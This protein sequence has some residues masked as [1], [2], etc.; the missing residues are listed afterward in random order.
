MMWHRF[1]VT[2]GAICLAGLAALANAQ[3]E[4]AP[5]VA[6]HYPFDIDVFFGFGRS[7][8]EPS[9]VRNLVAKLKRPTD[10][11]RN[12]SWC[13]LVLGYADRTEGNASATA[14]LAGRR[15]T[16]VKNIILTTWLHGPQLP[17]EAVG[18]RNT[19][20]PLGDTRNA[21]VEVE[22]LPCTEL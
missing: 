17:T 8:V 19:M 13:A 6:I 16:S 7:D 10:A 14:E 21:R 5:P 20:F 11:A 12:I 4:A 9:Q 22:I 1:A 15:V 18:T 3:V 2:S